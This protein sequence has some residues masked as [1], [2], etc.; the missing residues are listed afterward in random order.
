M[1]DNAKVLIRTCCVVLCISVGLS[2]V[3]SAKRPYIYLIDHDFL[4]NQPALPSQRPHSDHRRGNGA[5]ASSRKGVFGGVPSGNDYHK[6]SPAYPFITQDTHRHGEV[7]VNP[8][9]H[10]FQL[11]RHGGG[12]SAPP[13][14]FSSNSSLVNNPD[15]RKSVSRGKSKAKRRKNERRKKL[16]VATTEPSF[17]TFESPETLSFPIPW[18]W[19]HRMEQVNKAREDLNEDLSE[20][21][22]FSR[23]PKLPMRM[24][25]PQLPT[26]DFQFESKNISLKFG[27]FSF[28]HS[29]VSINYLFHRIFFVSH[30]LL[31]VCVFTPRES[32]EPL[33]WS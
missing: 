20:D 7:T 8:R 19:R 12:I 21:R 6:K 1:E 17:T 4:A 10:P 28:V 16:P 24:R 26:I 14:I 13:I 3:Y 5:T 2:V 9:Q 30:N 27:H 15:R 18:E 32:Y 31:R 11:Y 23:L 33:M 22:F 29:G 25:L